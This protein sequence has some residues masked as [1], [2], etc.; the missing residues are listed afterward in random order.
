ML[1]RSGRGNVHAKSTSEFL[2]PAKVGKKVRVEGRIA[3]KYTKRE[4]TYLVVETRLVD[5]DGLPLILY[6]HTRAF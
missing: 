1:P 4:K 3:E 2:N 6:R 5:E